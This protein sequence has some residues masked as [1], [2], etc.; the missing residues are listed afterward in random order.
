MGTENSVSVELSIVAFLV[1]FFLESRVSLVGMGNVKTTVT[2]SLKATED[3][4]TSG[5]SS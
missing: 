3:S 2:S 5:G 1:T 4:V